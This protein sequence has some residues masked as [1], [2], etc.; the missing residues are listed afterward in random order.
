MPYI[1]DMLLKLEGFQYATPLGLN[2][3]YYHIQISENASNLYM[4]I[5]PWVKYFYKRLPM[6]VANSQETFQHKM[7]YL[8]YVF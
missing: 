5:L 8:F 6:G 1:N 3:G 2:M 4:I 7:D